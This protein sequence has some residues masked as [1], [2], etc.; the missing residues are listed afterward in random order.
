VL[1][2]DSIPW[3]SKRALSIQVSLSPAQWRRTSVKILHFDL[4]P[5]V[6]DTIE[7]GV[8]LDRWVMRSGRKYF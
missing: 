1:E 8:V 3:D 4:M 2:N 7:V 6:K 5:L